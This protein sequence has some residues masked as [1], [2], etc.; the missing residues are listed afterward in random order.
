MLLL[1]PSKACTQFDFDCIWHHMVH[2]MHHACAAS[3]GLC[4]KKINNRT[5]SDILQLQQHLMQCP[6]LRTT[7]IIKQ[8]RNM[9]LLQTTIMSARPCLFTPAPSPL[10][11]P[12]QQQ[13]PQAHPAQQVTPGRPQS[14]Q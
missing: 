12:Q 11:L 8:C 1:S 3:A 2:A 9:H 10:S 6:P 7:L 4:N 13:T 5:L 14:W